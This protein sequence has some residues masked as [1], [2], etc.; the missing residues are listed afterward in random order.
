M[1]VWYHSFFLAEKT[2]PYGVPGFPY[3][4]AE[5]ADE[6]ELGNE[7]DLLLSVTLDPRLLLCSAVRTSTQRRIS[8]PRPEPKTSMLISYT[9]RI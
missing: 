8:R 7:V 4:R 1:L 6:Q 5:P 2:A 3:N 9:H